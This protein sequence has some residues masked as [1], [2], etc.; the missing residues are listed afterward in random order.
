MRLSRTL[1]LIFGALAFVVLAWVFMLYAQPDFMFQMA[2][3]V[4]GCF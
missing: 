3:Q 1:P 2:N 4:W